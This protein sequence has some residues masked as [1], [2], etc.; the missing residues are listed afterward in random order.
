[1][2]KHIRRLLWKGKSWN[3]WRIRNPHAPVDLT[4]ICTFGREFRHTN[5]RSVNLE[6]A[7]F[8]DCTFFE[9]DLSDVRLFN[10]H[11]DDCHIQECRLDDMCVAGMRL[12]YSTIQASSACRIDFGGSRLN[13][14]QVFGIAFTDCSFE[15]AMLIRVQF[16]NCSFEGTDFKGSVVSDLGFLN[17][18]LSGSR[19]LEEAHHVG[20]SSIGLDTVGRSGG[21]P[22]EFLVGSGTSRQVAEAISQIG[23]GPAQ[24]K[25][26]ASCF[27]SYSTHDS[28]FASLLTKD[29]RDAGVRVW[30]FPDDAQWGGPL[31]GE[32]D[33][34][35]HDHDR[36]IAV[37]SSNYFSSG[38]C[39]RELERA[40]ARKDREVREVLFPI[41]LDDTVFEGWDHYLK[42]DVQRLV[43]GDFTEYRDTVAYRASLKR[44]IAALRM[45]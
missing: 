21:L 42:G 18:D 32:I 40:L 11:F 17:C 37:L 4:A 24:E 14:C 2:G 8:G 22:S 6:M 27:I 35:I 20:P 16:V 25:N 13:D 1:M 7:K 41:R 38:A 10:S 30:M 43:I 23:P 9:C 36:L 5:F 19:G 31:W 15:G 33:R 26:L 29:L 39:Q 44:L 45:H 3:D 34:G 28:E 12:E